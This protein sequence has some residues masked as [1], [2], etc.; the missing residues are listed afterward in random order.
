MSEREDETYQN[1][2]DAV[3]AVLSGK[4]SYKWLHQN[5]EE[6]KASRRLEQKLMKQR[7]EKKKKS[8]K[9]KEINKTVSL[10][11]KCQQN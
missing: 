6:P 1:L 3:R 2:W 9:E 7:T 8:K 5:R 4:L 10:F 11:F